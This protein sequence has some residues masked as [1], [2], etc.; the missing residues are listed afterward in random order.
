[1]K[2]GTTELAGENLV[3]QVERDGHQVIIVLLGS[4]DRYSDARVIL[5]WLWANVK[6]YTFS[7]VKE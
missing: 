2:T 5:N 3:L 6:W 7:G 4:Q 1:M